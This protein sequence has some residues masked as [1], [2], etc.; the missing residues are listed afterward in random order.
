MVVPITRGVHHLIGEPHPRRFLVVEGLIGA[1]KTTLCRLIAESWG[2]ELVL[3]PSEHN[4]F[5]GPF[6]DDP[7]RFAFPVQ[8]FYLI[9]RW[10]QQ[11]GI[12]QTGLFEDLVVSDYLFAKD[13]L[14][15]EK[16]LDELEM[17]LYDRFAG[18]LGEHAPKPD[19]VVYLDVPT[20][21]L[22]RRIHRRQAVGE[23]KIRPEY[24]DDLRA[25]YERLWAEF[26]LAPVLRLDNRTMNYADEP[27]GR[28]RILELIAHALTSGGNGTT[29]ASG[30]PASASA[31][32]EGQP[33]LFGTGA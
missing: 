16:T 15:A 29:A 20:E 14:F 24:L 31:E 18:A 32:R 8:M 12:R 21:V 19:L 13:R 2:A 30:P 22:M 33:S 5:L 10:R 9:N 1:G 3:E 23:E 25:R 28:E 7:R 26:T 11:S 17:Q 4:P 6:Y 27:E